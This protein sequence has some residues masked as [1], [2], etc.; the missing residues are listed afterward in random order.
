MMMEN[1]LFIDM[2]TIAIPVLVIGYWARHEPNGI[3]QTL[4]ETHQSN[5][6]DIEVFEIFDDE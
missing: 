4:I 3:W 2:L 6:D 5:L 1:N